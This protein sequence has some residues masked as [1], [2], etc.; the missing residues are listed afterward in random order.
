MSIV[1]RALNAKPY[2]E[3]ELRW[4][5]FGTNPETGKVDYLETVDRGLAEAVLALINSCGW[6][7]RLRQM[8]RG[9]VRRRFGSPDWVNWHDTETDEY[10]FTS[11][12]GNGGCVIAPNPIR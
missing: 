2:D 6:D 1:Q 7:C 4:C 9:E 12:G 11:I 3:N 5:V 10:L 8:T